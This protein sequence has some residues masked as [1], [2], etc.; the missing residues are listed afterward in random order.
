MTRFLRIA[1]CP[2]AAPLDDI[3]NSRS[4]YRF[5]SRRQPAKATAA[6]RLKSSR[7]AFRHGLSSPLRNDPKTSAKINS[8][9][10]TLVGEEASEEQSKAGVEFAQAQMEL[11]RISATRLSLMQKE[12]HLEA[13]E[14][15]R[16]AAVDRYERYSQTRRRR[17]SCKLSVNQ[18]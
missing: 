10:K 2:I 4:L 11:L 6:G 16:I 5:L 14:L 15:R 7:N 3:R 9:V 12:E 8:I 17:A 1:L 18:T 13:E